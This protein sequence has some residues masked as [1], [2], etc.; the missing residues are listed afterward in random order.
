M[1]KESH[2]VL[3]CIP[4]RIG[5]PWCET[6]WSSPADWTEYRGLIHLVIKIWIRLNRRH[7]EQQQMW[8]WHESAAFS[9]VTQQGAQPPLKNTP[10]LQFE[11]WKS[12]E[13]QTRAKNNEGDLQEHSLESDAVESKYQ[14]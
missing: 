14:T 8:S 10:C 4:L 12:S 13:S 2:F 7:A 11:G 5:R 3:G 6:E 9:G 1:A